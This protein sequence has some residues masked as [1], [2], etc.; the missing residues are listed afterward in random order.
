[1]T[2][3]MKDNLFTK[4]K[5]NKQREH[6]QGHGCRQWYNVYILENYM[7]KVHV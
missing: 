7:Y 4:F 3:R 2:D 6:Q 1:M 5:G